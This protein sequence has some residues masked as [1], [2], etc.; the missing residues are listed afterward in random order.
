V[1]YVLRAETL[2]RTWLRLIIDDSQELEY[3]LDS[4]EQHT[5]R[6]RTGFRL[7]VGNAAGLKL[8]LNDKPLKA[9]G[10]RGEVVLLQLPD[11]SLMET[12]TSE[13]AETGGSP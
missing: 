4:N 10:E 12:S 8:Y 2:A 11:P 3:L 9:L 1:V 13:Y 7:R 5:W 6:A